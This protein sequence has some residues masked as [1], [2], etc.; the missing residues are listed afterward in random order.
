MARRRRDE[1]PEIDPTS[2]D[3]E[4]RSPRG[5]ASRSGVGAS[6]LEARRRADRRPP[7]GA[8]GAGPKST[9]AAS[10]RPAEPKRRGGFIGFALHSGG[11]QIVGGAGRVDREAA[12]NRRGPA[13]QDDAIV[14][15]ESVEDDA[16]TEQA[17]IAGPAAGAIDDARPA[18]DGRPAASFE[19][20]AEPDDAALAI[21]AEDD[22]WL[23]ADFDAFDDAPSIDAVRRDWAAPADDDLGPGDH[24]AVE[25]KAETP[26]A[27]R[28][29]D[30]NDAS[31][32]PMP[33]GGAFARMLAARSAV[34]ELPTDT[35]AP[36]DDAAAT[37]DA[38][39]EA[40]GA[41]IVEQADPVGPAPE[42]TSPVDA[43]AE[44]DAQA[45]DEGAPAAAAGEIDLG[46][47]AV[48]RDEQDPSAPQD[49]EKAAPDE[50][51]PPAEE[52]AA[53]A[54]P[55]AASDV[56]PAA[57]PAVAAV[58]IETPADKLRRRAAEARAARSAD[59]AS[60]RSAST[61]RGAAQRPAPVPED[62]AA[63]AER[64]A[65][66]SENS[67]GALLYGARA[68]LG[69]RD[70]SALEAE[71]KIKARVLSAIEAVDVER[72]PGDAYL[73]GYVR[74]Y[75]ARLSGALPLSP[76]AAWAKFQAER[77]AKL[78]LDAPSPAAAGPKTE[79]RPSA[80]EPAQRKLS[81]PEDAIRRAAE[82]ARRKEALAA[83]KAP[84]RR[85][86]PL[87]E[88]LGAAAAA[89]RAAT[90]GESVRE[91]AAERA[92]AIRDARRK[93]SAAAASGSALAGP[94]SAK[95]LQNDRT[96]PVAGAVGLAVAAFGYLAWMW[97]ADA[98]RVSPLDETDAPAVLD[99]TLTAP[100]EASD[101][102]RPAA[103]A[104]AAGGAL[105]GTDAAAA[106]AS[107]APPMRDVDPDGASSLA[108]E[109]QTAPDD[110]TA[111]DP[112]GEQAPLDGDGARPQPVLAD[113][114]AEPAPTE[115]P[116]TV[117][118]DET[119]TV[120]DAVEAPAAEPPPL[121]VVALSETWI[122]L[123]T[124]NG[125]VLFEGVLQAGATVAAP[126][127]RGPFELRSG[128]AGGVALRL[129]DAAFGPLGAVGAV[130]TFTVRADAD[131]LAALAT[132]ID[133]DASGL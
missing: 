124:A 85:Y 48:E 34:A 66:V 53:A 121:S 120:A 104:Y 72:L 67:L 49:V 119:A 79:D 59:A 2:S 86:A 62:P 129:G 51:A 106:P 108:L 87:S 111:T 80:P 1:R 25:E 128:N 19:E 44:T 103:D 18:R 69:L 30:E 123:R 68:S 42:E 88:R 70:L 11:P 12:S 10:E 4:A 105:S 84:E 14:D 64:A 27:A 100:T 131:A 28:D 47:E 40:D 63:A 52:P 24:A 93:A 58:A 99:E 114:G 83:T 82:A 57:T 113:V 6:W 20:A 39:L 118:A 89:A 37:E 107:A 8:E 23:D 125:E 16:T 7:R 33:N 41:M 96:W 3:D 90:D 45:D 97:L 126:D 56:A 13:A 75:A 122:R 116:A 127:G 94:F 26:V 31:A 32:A 78:G 9:D 81:A 29:G 22:P 112:A 15:D 117:A 71:L 21:D 17:Q 54:A 95:A 130:G 77:A 73:S 35:P 74:T 5:D 133:G 61:S 98:Q 60:D 43:T 65:F 76:D 101:V 110:Q 55:G 102:A 91:L 132:P 115:A 92:R 38:D 36:T 50:E 109:D 46:A